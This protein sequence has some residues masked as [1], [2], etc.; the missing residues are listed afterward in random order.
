MDQTYFSR[1]VH[2]EN[3]S[4]TKNLWQKIIIKKRTLSLSTVNIG[5]KIIGHNTTT[6]DRQ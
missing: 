1:Y 2:E 3:V 4:M 6:K 5:I